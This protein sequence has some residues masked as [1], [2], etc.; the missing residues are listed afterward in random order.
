M[1]ADYT[2]IVPA[3]DFT[4]PV[5]VAVDIG[6]AA[7]EAGWRVR[8]LCLT[9]TASRQD[10]GFAT[11]VRRFRLSDLWRLQGV[12]HTHCLRP[13]LLGLFLGWNRRATLVTT[14]HNFF[15][16]DV[17]FD[18]PKRY[19][20]IAWQLWKLALRRYDIVVCISRAMQRYY[21]RALPDQPLAMAYNFRASPACEP[22]PPHVLAWIQSRKQAGNTVLSF[23]GSLS[24]RKNI[25]G[26]ISALAGAR[27]LSLVVCGQGPLRERLE[28][29]VHELQ[30]EDRVMFVGQV[31]APAS[32]SCCTDALILPSF[33]EGFPLAV[34]EAAAVG[35]PTLLSNIAVHR[36]LADLG[37]G[38]TFDHRRF[39]D[40]ERVARALALARPAPSQELVELWAKEFSPAAGFERYAALINAST[41]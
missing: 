21:R 8:M 13:D 3:L 40:L 11:E 15:L 38:C 36:E 30:L 29:T 6:R 25:A 16:F 41:N 5:N 12:I 34:I 9:G 17:G 2:L 28:A 39:T 24:E 20:Q 22:A 7:A 10:L 31:H 26:L 1:R 27:S 14:I 4:G 37:F 19:T 35:T 32:I 33:A 23:V 18:H